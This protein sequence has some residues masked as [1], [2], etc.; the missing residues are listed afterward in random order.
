MNALGMSVWLGVA[1][2]IVGAP[3]QYELSDQAQQQQQQQQSQQPPQTKATPTVLNAAPVLA[4]SIYKIAMN[5]KTSTPVAGAAIYLHAANS[6]DEAAWIGPNLTDAYGRF[7]FQGPGNGEYVM[8]IYSGSL[9]LW[10][11]V[12]QLPAKL[13]PIVIRD[14]RVLYYPKSTD[15]ATV[16]TVLGKLGFPFEK[17]TAINAIPTNTIWFGNRV[18]VNDVKKIAD[19]LLRAGVNLRAIRRFHDGSDYKLKLVEVGAS[20]SRIAG[21]V[22]QPKD[23]D[24]SKD[25]P[26][27]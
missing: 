13:D 15:G 2:L 22:L 14:V 25:F 5:D 24:R 10:E 27:D 8:R 9:R 12:V 3:A 19:A 26:R 1:A 21:A 11:Q 6:Q 18:D 23:V 7:T 4:G 20:P 16:A 17:A